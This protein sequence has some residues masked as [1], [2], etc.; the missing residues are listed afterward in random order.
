MLQLA[1][2]RGD[3]SRDLSFMLPLVLPLAALEFR[4]LSGLKS[5]LLALACVVSTVN[6][7]WLLLPSTA[8]R[9]ALVTLGT[10]AA[11]G[12]ALRRRRPSQTPDT[13]E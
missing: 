12:L 1:V 9:Y 3:E 6:F 7:R 13:S 11:L 8:L 4:S 2:A 10:L 5:I